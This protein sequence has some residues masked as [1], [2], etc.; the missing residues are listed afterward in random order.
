LPRDGKLFIN[1]DNEWTPR[2]VARTKASVVRVGLGG[3][4]DWQA[5]D[6]R[7]DK[8]GVAF[9][10]AGPEK[11][12]SGEYRINLLGR[13]QVINALLAVAVGGELGLGRAEIQRGLTECKPPRMRLQ[14]WDLNGVRVLDDAYNANADSVIA[15]LETLQDLPCKG[16]RIA[17]LG[18]MAEL[19]AH[20]EAAHEEVGR[21]AAEL[22]VAQLFAVGKMAAVIAR[23]ARS[24]GLNRVF[25]FDNVEAAA[26][27]VGKFVKSG[28][29][30][31][32]KASRAAKL[33]RIAELLRAGDAKV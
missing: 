5:T 13:H 2:I 6:V 30:L 14:L 20:S 29:S 10:V 12:L 7:P 15:A 1:G 11:G 4:N 19:G 27:A 25:E 16:R 23:G 8:N 31:L 24:A 3:S 22:G 32:L 9:R 26:S 21:R 28:D 17:V 33:E 18:D